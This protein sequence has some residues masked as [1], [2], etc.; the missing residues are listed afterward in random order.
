MIK[1]E[2]KKWQLI[3]IYVTSLIFFCVSLSTNIGLLKNNPPLGPW[4][5][6]VFVE[7]EGINDFF[8]IYFSIWILL[9][10]API[11]F[12]YISTEKKKR[13]INPLIITGLMYSLTGFLLSHLIAIAMKPAIYLYTPKEEKES[14]KLKVKGQITTRIPFRQGITSI[15]WDNLVLEDGIIFTNDKQFDYL[16]YESEN[17]MPKHDDTGWVLKKQNGTV[18]WN[19]IPVDKNTL[20]EILSGILKKYGLFE[21]E[22]SD[23]NEYWFAE[24][25]KIFFD[26][27]EFTYGIYPISLEELDRI[28]SIETEL[29]YAEYIRVQF[30][31]KEID[32][33]QELSE[34]EYPEIKRS[35]YALHEWGMMKG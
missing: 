29:E 5:V 30:L 33:S 23:F 25:M 9:L 1:K 18:Y 2:M 6:N 31:V 15:L 3:I 12:T 17:I 20:S 14:L 4:T 28:F 24:D 32:E 7:P 34:P 22:I 16:F 35:E 13:I 19:Q 21:N 26:Q 10:V 11:L 8:I 27:D